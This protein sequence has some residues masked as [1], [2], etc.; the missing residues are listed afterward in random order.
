MQQ[1]QCTLALVASVRFLSLA[2]HRGGTIVH[3][4]DVKSSPGY[5]HPDALAQPL[6]THGCGERE[7]KKWHQFS[8]L[9]EGGGKGNVNQPRDWTVERVH[10]RKNPYPYLHP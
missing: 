7:K 1:A 9:C 5:N 6:A 3:G 4:N 2:H 10:S 8:S